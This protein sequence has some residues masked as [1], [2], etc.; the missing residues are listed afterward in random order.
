MAGNSVLLGAAAK[1]NFLP[2]S[3]ESLLAT[4]VDIVLAKHREMNLRAFN[5]GAEAAKSP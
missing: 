1:A 3:K 5:L 4:L 2:L